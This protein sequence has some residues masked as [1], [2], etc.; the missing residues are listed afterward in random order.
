MDLILQGLN[1][2]APQKVPEKAGSKE[3]VDFQGKLLARR[4][5]ETAV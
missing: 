5:C 4:P 3:L 1:N 2:D